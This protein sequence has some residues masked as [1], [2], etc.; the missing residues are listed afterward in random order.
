MALLNDA[1]RQLFETAAEWRQWLEA[2]HASSSG[3]FL[4]YWKKATGRPSMS[5][6]EMVEQALCFGWVDSRP[7]KLDEERTML[8]FTPRKRGSA[9]AGPNKE[10]IE[11]LTAAGLMRPAGIALVE[12]AKADGTWTLLDAVE[13]LEVPGDLAARLE[14]VEGARAQWDNFPR[15]ARRGILE[16]IVQAKTP[17][18]RERR[19][20]ETA[21]LAGR[22]ERANQW[23]PKN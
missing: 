2:N 11:R 1:P 4:I 21:E 13:R 22:G 6:D 18:T 19:V 3:I 9:W 23:S 12:A 5:Y 20:T 17:A 15:S 8:W 14:A 7:A 16:W 10:R